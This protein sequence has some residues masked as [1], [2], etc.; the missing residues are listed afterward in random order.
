MKF[1]QASQVVTRHVAGELVLVCTEPPA[2][3]S[4]R[5]VGDFFVLNGSA[6]VLWEALTSAASRAD[7][8]QRLL[9]HYELSRE[10][11][12]SDVDDFLATLKTFGML[13][14]VERD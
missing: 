8:A 6:E 12:L 14:T 10:Q 9:E 1:Q 2:E 7:L 3:G 4:A 13:D 11:A 5:Q